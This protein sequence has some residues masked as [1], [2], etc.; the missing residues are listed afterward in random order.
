V[1]D[2]TVAVSMT[3]RNLKVAQR[4]LEQ[5]QEK[6]EQWCRDAFPNKTGHLVVRLRWRGR[7]R[8]PAVVSAKL[9]VSAAAAEMASPPGKAPG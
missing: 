3:G 2:L 8:F 9:Y 6:V 5:N 1:P 4:W 7:N